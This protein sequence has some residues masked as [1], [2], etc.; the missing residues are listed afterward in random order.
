MAW[1]RT[2]PLDLVY[3][4]RVLSLLELI[5]AYDAEVELSRT[6]I[7]HRFRAHREYRVIQ[8]ISAIGPTFPAIFITKIGDI[9]RSSRPENQSQNSWFWDAAPSA[10]NRPR[11]VSGVN[12]A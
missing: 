2:A 7:S 8:Q 9:T 3:R 12:G 5:N 10:G 1:L 4:Q 11:R 6:M